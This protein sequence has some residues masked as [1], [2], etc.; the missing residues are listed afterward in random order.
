MDDPLIVANMLNITFGYFIFRQPFPSIIE[1]V[2]DPNEKQTRGEY[3]LY[4]N[5]QTLC[6]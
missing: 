1:L 6:R 5:I 2:M 3:I 4:Q